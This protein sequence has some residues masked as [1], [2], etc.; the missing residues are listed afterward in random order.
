VSLTK[1][2][3]ATV[4]SPFFL[5]IFIFHNRVQLQ[6]ASQIRTDGQVLLEGYPG[7]GNADGNQ[8]DQTEPGILRAVADIFSPHFIIACLLS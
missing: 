8:Y 6:S 4:W 2:Q 3:V 1:I 5:N 7:N